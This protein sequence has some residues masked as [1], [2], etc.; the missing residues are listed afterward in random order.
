MGASRRNARTSLPWTDR[1]RDRCALHLH[2]ERAGVDRL[3]PRSSAE[4]DD[5]GA[6][7]GV[8]PLAHNDLLAGDAG[9]SGLCCTLQTAG[10][11]I[12]RPP[13]GPPRA[14]RFSSSCPCFASPSPSSPTVPASLSRS[15]LIVMATHV[16]AL[17]NNTASSWWKDPSLRRNVAVAFVCYWATFALGYDGSY[18]TG[19][20]SMPA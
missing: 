15:R 11:V 5:E 18:M 17:P 3:Q 7:A 6:D 19:L 9:Q 12:P 16:L 20:Q 4:L 8:G 1:A 10:C 14:L 13:R 2:A